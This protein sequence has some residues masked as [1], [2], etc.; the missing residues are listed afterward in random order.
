MAEPVV[1]KKKPLKI[2][3]PDHIVLPPPHGYQDTKRSKHDTLQAY[4]MRKE[5]IRKKQRGIFRKGLTAEQGFARED[6]NRY[7]ADR[8]ITD[9]APYQDAIDRAMREAS[10]EVPRGVGQGVKRNAMH[11]YFDAVPEDLYTQL[12][13]E[14]Q[15]RNKRDLD[16]ALPTD[17]ADY[18][19]PTTADDQLIQEMLD[20]QRGKAENYAKSLLNRGVVNQRGYDAAIED[21]LG[22]QPRIQ[23][24]LQ[25]VGSN[26]LAGGRSNLGALADKARNRASTQTLA[27]G[28]FDI[29][30]YTQDINN[31]FDEF[32]G[33]LG[34]QFQAQ[35]GQGDLFTTSQLASKAGQ[36]MGPQNFRFDT[37][38]LSGADPFTPEEEEDRKA[39][40][41]F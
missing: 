16:T 13:S 28:P 11:T 30:K 19:I 3:N 39:K 22:Q 26:L 23:G 1:S 14:Q 20:S 40:P 25:D 8:G 9:L 36:A 12:S 15:T 7:F 2:N 4:N 18:R 17:F 24:M 35:V 10:Q 34:S 27:Q 6:I 21:I 32:M 37:R 38:A 41:I 5:A 33:G 29:N 31:A